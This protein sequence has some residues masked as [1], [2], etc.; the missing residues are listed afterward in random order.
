MCKYVKR[1]AL[2]IGKLSKFYSCSPC[3]GITPAFLFVDSCQARGRDFDTSKGRIR[4]FLF[5]RAVGNEQ[6][7]FKALGHMVGYRGAFA[8]RGNHKIVTQLLPRKAKFF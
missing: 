7:Q 6:H 8:L 1:Q 5:F 2:Q 4:F 3:H